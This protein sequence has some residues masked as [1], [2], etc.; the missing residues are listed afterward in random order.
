M[1]LQRDRNRKLPTENTIALINIVFL[2]LIFFLIA[3]SIAPPID[4]EINLIKT[5]DASPVAPPLALF[6][7]KDAELRF[8]GTMVT[9][10]SY[11]AQL[12][13]MGDQ[14]PKK[15]NTDHTALRDNEQL[16]SATPAPAGP[17]VRLAADGN[18]PAPGLVAVV[19]QLRRA[20]AG[21]VTIVT[22]RKAH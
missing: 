6:V 5:A 20:G 11:I 19:D 7:T 10:A 1:K 3:G 13:T 9:P 15:P 12:R 2:M 14:N 8:R 21:S 16:M 22:E 18:L 17:A 4:S